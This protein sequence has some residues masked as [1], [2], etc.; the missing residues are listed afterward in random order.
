VS[1]IGTPRAVADLPAGLCVAT[2]ELAAPPQRVFDALASDEVCRWWVRPG[3]F[4]TRE[5]SGDVRPGGSWHAAGIGGGRPYGLE[6]EFVE[7]ERPNRL[8]HTWKLSGTPEAATTIEYVLEATDSGT[9]VTLRQAK[10]ANR[11]A[12]AATAL[13]WETS[14][15]ELARMLR[16]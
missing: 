16:S 8:V 15:E 6:G 2:V 7:V 12:C 10:F 3:V 9:R 11:G 4:D 13:G 1:N 5:W 14:F